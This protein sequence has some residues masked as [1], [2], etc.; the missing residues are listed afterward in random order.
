MY[1][2]HQEGTYKYDLSNWKGLD[3]ISSTCD[4]K[5][6]TDCEIKQRQPAYIMIQ[7]AVQPALYTVC[8]E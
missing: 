4:G 7:A 3:I 6:G 5:N 2:H 1:K 8:I